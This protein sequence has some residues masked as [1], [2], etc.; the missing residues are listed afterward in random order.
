MEIIESELV[1]KKGTAMPTAMTA[2]GH[3]TMV[4]TLT[5]IARQV[6][7]TV[8][9]IANVLP[10]PAIT[11]ILMFRETVPREGHAL[12]TA[13]T[14]PGATGTMS[15]IPG[16]GIRSVSQPVGKIVILVSPT[17]VPHNPLMAFV[18][19]FVRMVDYRFTAAL[20][21]MNAV[22]RVLRRTRDVNYGFS[23]RRFSFSSR[24]WF[25]P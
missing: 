7:P 6:P 10:M 22:Q 14:A 2:P 19:R 1:I 23:S 8:Q 9:A 15:A 5:R 11:G 25:P 21:A 13:M 4:V 3:G 17:A 20:I 12:L 16:V 24:Q 18:R